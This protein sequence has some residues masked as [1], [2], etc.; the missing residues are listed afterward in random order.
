MK[1]PFLNTHQ[2]LTQWPLGDAKQNKGK[3]FS[4]AN[5]YKCIFVLH[6]Y[7]TGLGWRPAFSR[8]HLF[9]LWLGAVRQQAITWVNVDQGLCRHMASLS[10]NELTV[11]IRHHCN[12]SIIIKHDIVLLVCHFSEHSL[13]SDKI[14]SNIMPYPN[15]NCEH[16]YIQH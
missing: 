5:F 2:C 9:R 3:Q 8:Q 1:I 15:T 6:T 10:L 16:P 7:K 4:N 13:A 11:V 12:M 14:R